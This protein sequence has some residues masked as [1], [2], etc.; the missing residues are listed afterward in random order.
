MNQMKK[1]NPLD[2]LLEIDTENPSVRYFALRDLLAL[3]ETNVKVREARAAIMRSGPVPIILAGQEPFGAWVKPGSGYSPKYR[4]TVWSL[5]ILAELGADPEEG[6]IRKGCEYLLDHSLASNGA[7]SAYQKPVPSG[8]FHC[9][10]GNLI[11]TLQRLGYGGDPR[12]Q[13][14]RDWLARSIVGQPPIAYH[15]SAVA[16]PGFACGVNERQPCAWGANKAIRALLEVPK[17][18]R[19]PLIKSALKAGAEFLLSRDPVVADYPYTR[20]VSSTWFKLGF[21]LSYWSDILETVSNLVELG[22][23]KDPRLNPGLE[24]IVSKQ[25]ENG[26]WKLENGLNG[27]MWVNLETKG[28]PSKWVSL[29][30]L[31]VLKR[32]GL[33]VPPG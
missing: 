2:W 33:Y 16:A 20:R 4:S 7:F 11:L 5:L 21:P 9:L 18:A 12:V 13:T 1:A 17:E 6:R 10:N 30:A 24:W 22:Y 14:A 15:A 19:S 23:G 25:D 3:P 31:R 27:K 26:R 29:R 8:T 32:V 28:K